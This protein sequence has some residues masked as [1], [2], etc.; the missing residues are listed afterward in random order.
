[1][2]VD[3]LRRSERADTDNNRTR[4]KAHLGIFSNG[5]HIIP[6]TC[7]LGLTKDERRTATLSMGTR[8]AISSIYPHLVIS[9]VA[10]LW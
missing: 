10:A 2:R 6:L 9:Q 4:A 8:L 7:T 3:N 1:M 5:L